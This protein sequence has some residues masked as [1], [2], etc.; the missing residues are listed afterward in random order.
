MSFIIKNNKATFSFNQSLDNNLNQIILQLFFGLQAPSNADCSDNVLGYTNGTCLNMIFVSNA[1]QTI[2]S[3]LPVLLKNISKHS[4]YLTKIRQ[5]VEMVLNYLIVRNLIYS[6]DNL[7][8]DFTKITFRL[9]QKK[10]AI[11]KEYFIDGQNG[12]VKIS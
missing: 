12:L 2:G 1:G 5:E 7:V 3:Q 4:S 9:L 10:D 6:Y 11:Y 8:V